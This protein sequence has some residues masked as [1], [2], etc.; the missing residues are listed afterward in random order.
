MLELRL[1]LARGEKV[2]EFF[3]GPHSLAPLAFTFGQGLGFPVGMAIA[4]LFQESSHG[5][6][7]PL[8]SVPVV[9]VKTLIAHLVP[10]FGVTRILGFWV[11]LVDAF[12]ILIIFCRQLRLVG[13]ESYSLEVKVEKLFTPA[14]DTA[15][16]LRGVDFIGDDILAA[17]A[18]YRHTI[19]HVVP[20]LAG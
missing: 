7:S 17:A 4:L 11:V 2:P 18:K 1:F 9:R 12:N 19:F 10:G 14:I 20:F 15:D 3:S 8:E 16:R 13:L 5:D 6:H